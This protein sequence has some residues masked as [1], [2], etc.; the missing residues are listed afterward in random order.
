MSRF[1]LLHDVN[2]N[3]GFLHIVNFLVSY[4][5]MSLEQ[6]GRFYERFKLGE[7][8]VFDI[9]DQM[10]STF[11]EYLESLNCKYEVLRQ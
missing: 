4:K 6:A 8:V 2:K 7:D 9:P 3:V 5:I 11:K 1:M 10:A